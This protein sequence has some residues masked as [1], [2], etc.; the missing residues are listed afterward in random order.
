[1]SRN[2][3]HVCGKLRGSFFQSLDHALHASA[4]GDVNK[5]KTVAHEVVAHVHEIV[6]WEKDDGGG[7]GVAGRKMQRA[8]IFAVKMHGDVVLKGNDGERSL[9]GGLVLHFERAAV[10]CCATSRETFAN[11][12]LGDDSRTGI[13]DR[14]ITAC[15]YTVHVVIYYTTDT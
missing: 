13:G 14:S 15:M 6:F 11:I 9:F 3:F 2:N 10:A 12:I 7:I 5:R 1:M 8:N 4:A